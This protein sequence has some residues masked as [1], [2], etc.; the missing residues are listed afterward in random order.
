MALNKK[1]VT[2]IKEKT[3]DEQFLKLHLPAL[4][5]R[6]ESGRQPKRELENIMREIKP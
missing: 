1:I 6:I 2:K 5:S 4:L 3:A